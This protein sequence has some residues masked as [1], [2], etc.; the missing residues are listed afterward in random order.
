VEL[1][2]SHGQLLSARIFLDNGPD[3]VAIPSR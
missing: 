2:Y 1:T 3:I